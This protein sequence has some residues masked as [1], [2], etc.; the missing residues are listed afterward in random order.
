MILAI[1]KFVRYGF[2]SSLLENKKIFLKISFVYFILGL[3]VV[4]GIFLKKTQTQILGPE[5][6]GVFCFWISVVEI[7]RIFFRFGIFAAIK[8]LLAQNKD[9]H[10]ELFGA[11][12][13]IGLIVGIMYAGCFWGL[14]F[15]IDLFFE[16]KIGWLLRM[17]APLTFVMPYILLIEGIAVGSGKVGCFLFIENF[18][19]FGLLTILWLGWA[20]TIE[21][22]V[23]FKLITVLI[24]VAGVFIYL[25][26]SF[27]NMFVHLK[28]IIKTTKSYGVHLYYGQ[29]SDQ[30]T[31]HLD[32]ICISFFVNTTQLGFYSLAVLLFSPLVMIGR[33]AGQVLFREYVDKSCIPIRFLLSCLFILFL[34]CSFVLIFS[35][36]FVLLLFGESFLPVCQF[37]VPLAIAAF[38][39]AAYQLPHCFLGS[40]GKSKWMRNSS[41]VMSGVNIVGNITLAHYWGAIGVAWASVMSLSSYALFIVYY[42]I[43]LTRT[44]DVPVQV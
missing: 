6:F 41:F 42:Y 3:S 28:A 17:S 18:S 38:I 16:Q 29:L 21:K 11:S 35:K 12:L 22:I 30:L 8:Y 40:K 7:T 44:N 27:K 33:S 2:F 20:N 37:C 9:N 5:I 26:P 19:R 36:T 14:G 15:V 25:K 4:S 24:G 39:H 43:K 13:I 32:E 31:Y 34:C 23:V 1:I 10:S